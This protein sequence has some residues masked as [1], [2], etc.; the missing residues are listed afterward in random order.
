M[1]SHRSDFGQMLSRFEQ[2][3]APVTLPDSSSRTAGIQNLPEGDASL[4]MKAE[5]QFLNNRSRPA[6]FTEFFLLG[7]DLDQVVA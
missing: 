1:V 6:G 3:R 5:V 4:N 2:A 7:S